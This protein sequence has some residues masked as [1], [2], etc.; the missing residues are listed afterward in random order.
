MA[1]SMQ[2]LVGEQSTGIVME[3]VFSTLVAAVEKIMNPS[4]TPQERTVAHQVSFY[5]YFHEACYQLNI[6][7]SISVKG[8]SYRLT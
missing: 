5:F 2:N 7:F 3:Q 6:K 8:L 1:S 4:A